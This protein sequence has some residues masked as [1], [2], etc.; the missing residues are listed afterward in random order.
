MD[1]GK[2]MKVALAKAGKD[3]VWLSDQVDVSYIH[4][5]RLANQKV[6]TGKMITKMADA[7]DMSTSEF[8][9]LGEE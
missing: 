5:S 8:I 2:S 1:I 3:R 6:A 7:F 9:K 4:V